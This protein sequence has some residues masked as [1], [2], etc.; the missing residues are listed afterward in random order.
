[1]ENIKQRIKKF[2]G[3]ELQINCSYILRFVT[4]HDEYFKMRAN[5][6]DKSSSA[7][8][9]C[10]TLTQFRFERAEMQCKINMMRGHAFIKAAEIQRK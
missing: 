2:K 1:M 3:H 10:T 4:F 5:Q 7:S 8:S 9:K 6:T